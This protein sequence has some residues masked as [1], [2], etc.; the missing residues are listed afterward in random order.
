MFVQTLKETL[1]RFI[2]D[3]HGNVAIIFGLAALPLFLAGGIAV[4]YGRAV[5]TK[6]HMQAA[7]DAAALAAASMKNADEQQRTEMA[8]S[9]FTANF[10]APRGVRVDPISVEF[11]GEGL[12]VT[13][14]AR[15]E[16]VLMKLAGLQQMPL[17]TT[18]EV[19]LLQARKAEIALVLDYSGSMGQML[20]GERKY[21]TMRN[22]AKGL[23]SDIA[24]K[25]ADG[26]VK[27]GGVGHGASGGQRVRP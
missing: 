14:T 6:N 22:A 5:V 18:T 17:K 2:A 11:V 10:D 21:V 23:V 24:D 3:V 4:D 12:R 25:A 16:T 27:V 9:V 26:D 1:Q 19:N 13:Q 15:V 7:A 8:R 20:N